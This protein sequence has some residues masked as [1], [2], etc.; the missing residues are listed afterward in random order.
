VWAIG[1][2]A[3]LFVLAL[4]V[5]FVAVPAAGAS[6][7]PPADGQFILDFAN[8]LNVDDTR[9]IEEEAKR[10]LAEQAIPL[11]VLTLD[12]MTDR[13]GNRPAVD[14]FARRQFEAW[15]NHPHFPYTENW[16]RGILLLVSVDDRKARIELGAAWAGEYNAPCERIMHQI[17]VPAFKQGLYSEG[18][19]D[20]AEALARMGRGEQVDV[21]VFKALEYKLRSALVDWEYKAG[22][23]AA[24][25]IVMLLSSWL[26]PRRTS[27]PYSYSRSSSGSSFGGFGGGGGA[28]GSW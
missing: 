2:I 1:R 8:L 18:I 17:L 10:L 23:F 12:S 11:V 28:S 5:A 4:Q 9:R 15:G 6:I 27:N 21:S 25:V 7:D 24:T 16:R 26:H 19:T 22:I 14:I 3:S 20:G 13:N